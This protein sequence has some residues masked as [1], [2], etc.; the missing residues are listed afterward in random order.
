MSSL[1]TKKVYCDTTWKR[2]DSKSTSAFK[3]TFATNTKITRK[4]QQLQKNKQNNQQQFKN[5]SPQI[6]KRR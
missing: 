3:N 1:P 2:Y 5:I 4:T 6:R